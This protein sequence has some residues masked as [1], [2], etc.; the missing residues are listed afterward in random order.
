MRSQPACGSSIVATDERPEEPSQDVPS[1]LPNLSRPLS[2]NSLRL[3]VRSS[4]KC[5]HRVKNRLNGFLHARRG[6]T[7]RRGQDD[8]VLVALVEEDVAVL[9]PSG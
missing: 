6:G 3:G 8:N 1:L 7:Q 5:T 4:V 9:I 2:H